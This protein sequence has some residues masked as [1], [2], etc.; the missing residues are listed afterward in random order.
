[1]KCKLD[2][3][4][5]RALLAATAVAVIYGAAGMAFDSAWVPRWSSIDAQ[6]LALPA[7]A[8][9]P[10]EFARAAGRRCPQCGW[11]ESR[12]EIP[13]NVGDPQARALY[14]YTVRRADGSS[15]VFREGLPA[16]WRPGERVI[17]IEGSVARD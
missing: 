16:S 12:L 9:A 5:R 11:I 14:E 8:E 2:R 3:R 4:A 6:A 13:P 17:F 15:G 1:M 10:R 7:R